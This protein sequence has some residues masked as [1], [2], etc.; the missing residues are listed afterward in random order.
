MPAY[1]LCATKYFWTNSYRS[2]QLTSTCFFWHLLQ[3]SHYFVKLKQNRY[4]TM[5]S[6]ENSTNSVDT[7]WILLISWTQQLFPLISWQGMKSTYMIYRGQALNSTNFV[8]KLLCK[9]CRKCP[10]LSWNSKKFS[11]NKNNNKSKFPVYKT[12]SAK[13]RGQKATRGT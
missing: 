3:Y 2:L 8:D 9:Q 1:S 10:L 6:A 11:K 4:N 7:L 13:P 12:A 5:L